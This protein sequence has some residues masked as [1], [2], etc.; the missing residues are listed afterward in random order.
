MTLKAIVFLKNMS[1]FALDKDFTFFLLSLI[2]VFSKQLFGKNLLFQ[3]EIL[4]KQ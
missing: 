4:T 3:L 1:N 2:I